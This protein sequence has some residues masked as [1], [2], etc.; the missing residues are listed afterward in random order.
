[1]VYNNVRHECNLYN[2][3][4][5]PRGNR[6]MME[7]GRKIAQ[8]YLNPFDKIIGINVR[9]GMSQIV[10]WYVKRCIPP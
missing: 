1:M 9:I 7:L 8:M 10:K 3:F 2:F 6:R 4:F 5:A